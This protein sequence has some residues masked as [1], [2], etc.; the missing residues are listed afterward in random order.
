VTDDNEQHELELLKLE[1]K[2]M[3]SGELIEDTIELNKANLFFNSLL[4][5]F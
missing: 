3:L 4:F 1:I 2:E 5:M